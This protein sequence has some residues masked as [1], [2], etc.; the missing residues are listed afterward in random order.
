MHKLSLPGLST[1][2]TTSN[3]DWVAYDYLQKRHL[4]STGHF[5]LEALDYAMDRVL[6]VPERSVTG[7]QLAE[8][9]FRDGKRVIATRLKRNSKQNKAID[10]FYDLQ[11]TSVVSEIL[12]SDRFSYA[13]EVIRKAL[14]SLTPKERT[15][16]YLRAAGYD[17][18]EVIEDILHIGRRQYRNVL[19]QSR[20]KLEQF[21]GF[22][23]SYFELIQNS[24]VFNEKA[25]VLTYL[26]SLLSISK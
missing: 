6:E 13:N 14:S 19:S 17:S 11:P 5:Q 18:Q 9:L 7:V 20:V 4:K 25:D 23:D 26:E 10:Q 1:N 3:I 21:S 15:A 8:Y 2:P 22:K 12:D 24:D 16:L